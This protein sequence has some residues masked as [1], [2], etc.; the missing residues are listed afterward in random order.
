[1]A[2]VSIIYRKDK[3]NKKD[4]APIH[5]R[6]IKDRKISYL[7]TGF[8]V[9]QDFWDFEKNQIKSKHPNSK[10]IKSVLA[11]KFSEAQDKVFDFENKNKSVTSRKIRNEVYGNKPTDFIPF[12]E[13]LAKE[14]YKNGGKIGT[15]NKNLSVI[16]KLRTYADGRSFT[17]YD[18]DSDFL[19]KYETYLRSEKV[20]NTTNTIG[21]DYKYLRRIFNEA[22]RQDI[23]EHKDNPFLKY[24][25][26]SEK[27]QREY[28][29]DDE[30]KL[31]E[32]CHT[33]SGTRLDLHKDM[34]IF[35]C[36]VGGIR[37][38]DIL[39]IRWEQFDGVHLNFTTMKTTSQ[40]SIK[41]PI[42]GL[43]ILAKYKTDEV[44]K[45]DF[46]FPML[47]KNLKTNDDVIL[48]KAIGCASSYINKNLG[49]IRKKL[50]LKKHISFHVSRNSW[51]TRAL[52][53]G[54]R[55][56][57]VSKILTHSDLKTTQIY[58]KIVNSELDKAMDVFN[59]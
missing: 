17:F 9:H 49:I 44:E 47:E 15:Y 45:S 31:I 4:E 25:I 8:M 59:D 34:F 5:F 2:S 12:A 28:L 29:T 3:L 37:I 27:T 40:I 30:I 41:I 53:K 43:E 36:Y 46:I 20:K 32:E 10:R 24:Q 23:I 6:I 52:R 7:A 33:T 58:A 26:K 1:M 19:I 42:K 56:E 16:E 22:I 18:I 54:M 51:A 39:Q 11:N 13:K 57:Y 55:I 21:K 14:S 35:A 50:E 48:N 38:S